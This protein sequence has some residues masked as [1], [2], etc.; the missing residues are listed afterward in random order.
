MLKLEKCA[1]I[2]ADSAN[3]K[4]SDT[5]SDGK[6]R[7]CHTSLGEQLVQSAEAELDLSCQTS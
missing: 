6:L 5:R 4:G 3:V 2:T 1:E 7:L